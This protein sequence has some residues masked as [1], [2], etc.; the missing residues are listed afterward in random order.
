VHVAEEREYTGKI[1]DEF[2]QVAFDDGTYV[3]SA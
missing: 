1:G 2:G 3:D